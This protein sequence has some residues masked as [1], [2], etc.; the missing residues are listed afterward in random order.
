MNY[1]FLGALPLSQTLFT[2]HYFLKPNIMIYN[3]DYNTNKNCNLCVFTP[4][5]HS[6]FFNFFFLQIVTLRIMHRQFYISKPN[7]S[8][9]KNVK[10]AF[11][12]YVTLSCN[13]TLSFLGNLAISRTIIVEKSICLF[14]MLLK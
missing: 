13:S 3:N 14:T 8:L 4:K 6:F 12:C 2:T 11:L 5:I 1:Q 7:F 10:R 9:I